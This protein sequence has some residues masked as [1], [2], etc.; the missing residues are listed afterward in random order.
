LV[1]HEADTDSNQTAGNDAHIYGPLFTPPA[2]SFA[3]GTRWW[4]YWA[5]R[6]ADFQVYD[7][8]LSAEE[9]AYLATDGTGQI[10]IP[11]ISRSNFYLDGGTAG[12]GNQ[13]VNFEDLSVMGSQWHTI[14]LWP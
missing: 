8:A 2:T 13:I 9:V 11:L 5:G 7:Y 12:D 14:I 3:I 6:I 10:I 1:G 4:A